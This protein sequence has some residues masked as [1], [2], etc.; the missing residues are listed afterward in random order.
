MIGVSVSGGLAHGCGR[1]PSHFRKQTTSKSC[2]LLPLA[3]MFFPSLSSAKLLCGAQAIRQ[4]TEMAT[5]RRLEFSTLNTAG[6]P[7]RLHRE[8]TKEDAVHG[9]VEKTKFVTG[10][11]SS[12][13]AASSLPLA[14]ASKTRDDGEER[15]FL[16]FNQRPVCSIA[17][18]YSGVLGCE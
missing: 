4:R 17:Y 13:R 1:L 10:V 12:G 16:E 8:V 11:L 14:A 18:L 15:T 5:G 6:V 3:A 2:S 7:L 9:T